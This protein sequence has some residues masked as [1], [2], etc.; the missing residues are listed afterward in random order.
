[1]RISYFIQII[2]VFFSEIHCVFSELMIG[3]SKKV[4]HKEQSGINK[5]TLFCTQ[6]YNGINKMESIYSI[7]GDDFSE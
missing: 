7:E 3:F 6:I 1:M 2:L 4:P 5:M